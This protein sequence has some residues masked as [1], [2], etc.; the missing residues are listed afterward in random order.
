MVKKALLLVSIVYTIALVIVSFINLYNLPNFGSDFDDKIYHIVAYLGL[1]FLWIT[2]FKDSKK[3][4]ELLI[5]F[6]TIVIFG[7]I[8]ETLQHVLNPNR[9]YDVYDIVANCIGAILGTLIAF[10]LNVFKLK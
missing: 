8:I 6:I 9:T 4:R 1:A 7:F 2:Y 10:R 3:T 5:V